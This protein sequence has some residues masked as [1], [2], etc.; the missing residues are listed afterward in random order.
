MK[1]SEIPN[2]IYTPWGNN[3][4]G[5]YICEVPV[6]SQLP[7]DPG[8]ASFADG[9]TP[10]N[11]TPTASGGIQPDGR[12]MNGIIHSVTAWE[13]WMACGGHVIYDA[14]FQA[15]IG[16]YPKGALVES[17]TDPMTFW[18]CTAENNMTDPDN[19]GAGWITWPTYPE[20]QRWALIDQGSFNPSQIIPQSYSD[21]LI[22][23]GTAYNEVTISY[24]HDNGVTFGSEYPFNK[25]GEVESTFINAYYLPAPLVTCD[26][27][28]VTISPPSD[29][30]IFRMHVKYNLPGPVTAIK[31]TPGLPGD[32]NYKIYAR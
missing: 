20:R 2:K 24:S 19:S 10:D 11:L 29:Y 6:N 27:S 28:V 3:A 7:G 15:N 32:V 22:V 31:L 1:A 21:L 12:D 30:D 26:F 13:K 9:F 5:S 25:M 8:R 17:A 16:G 23:P 14:T 4:G 18:Y